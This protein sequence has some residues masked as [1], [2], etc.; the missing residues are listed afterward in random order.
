MKL[1]KSKRRQAILCIILAII[2]IIYFFNIVTKQ[3]TT[4]NLIY[5][6]SLNAVV[7]VSAKSFSGG[8]SSGS[9]VFIDNSGRLITNAHVVTYTNNKD[10]FEFDNYYIRFMGDEK[11]YSVELINYDTS[12]DLAVL[13]LSNNDLRFNIFKMGDSTKLKGG[14]RIYAISNI[15]NYG[16]SISEGI[17]GIPTL[18]IDNNGHQRKVI[19]CDLTIAKGSSGGALLDSRGYLIGITT[20]RLKDDQGNIIYGIAYSIPINDIKL[21]IEGFSR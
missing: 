14:D 9:A 5:E 21:Y 13:K 18:I 15:M 16:L 17:V 4:T 7:E 12:I 10:V 19:Q 2:F 1:D 11:Y 20:F 8:K 3:I 6:Y